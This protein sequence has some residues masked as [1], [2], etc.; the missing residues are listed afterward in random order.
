MSLDE[1]ILIARQGKPD[2]GEPCNHCGW[3]CLIEPCLIGQMITGQT[4]G[5]CRL[6]E[7]HGP[8]K[9]LCGVADV[10]Q[11]RTFNAMG[12]GCDAITTDEKLKAL[13]GEA[14]K[15]LA[16]LPTWRELSGA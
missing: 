2:Y 14:P 8:K 5:A 15:V 10:P 1:Q 4:E 13:N 9:Y 16:T 3:C 6:L 11:V 7:Y 12:Q